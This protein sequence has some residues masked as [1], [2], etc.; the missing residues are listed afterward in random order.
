MGKMGLAP[1]VEPSV[2]SD[3]GFETN[4]FHCDDNAVN[5]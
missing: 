3:D 1:S 4:V 5:S 2:D